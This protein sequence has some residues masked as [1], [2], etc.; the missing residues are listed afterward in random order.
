MPLRTGKR[1]WLWGLTLGVLVLAL[2][3]GLYVTFSDSDVKTF[4]T[5]AGVKCQSRE[6]LDFHQH[7]HLSILIRGEL[8]PVSAEIGRTDDCLFWLHTHSDDGLVHIEAPGDQG[9]T[10]GQFF[11]IWDQ[12]LSETTLLTASAG[13]GE[14]V[15]AT[16]DGAAFDGNPSDIPLNDEETIVLQLGPPFGTPPG[17]PFESD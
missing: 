9:F 7:A 10:L 2:G 8:V 4:A 14:E 16:V 13:G 5:T 17:S 12:P 1:D 6:R 11:A 3:V 15:T